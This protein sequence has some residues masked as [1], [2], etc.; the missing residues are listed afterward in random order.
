MNH[1]GRTIITI[2][3]GTY[4]VKFGMGAL[5]HFS[6]GLGYDVQE[7][8]TALTKPGVGQIKSI[9][10]FIYAALY[11]DA[12]YKEKEFIL[13]FDD[14]I[15][16]VDSNATDEISKVMVVI[17]QGISSITKVDYPSE[18]AGGSKKK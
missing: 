6:E 18:D 3:D 10:K 15:D 4:P 7:T 2:N 14:V 9:A 5:L 16:W 11:V 1:T 12:L 8:I 17:M 13:T